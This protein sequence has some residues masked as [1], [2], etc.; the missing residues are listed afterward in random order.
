VTDE[1]P[2][3]SGS[4]WEPAAHPRPTPAASA[5]PAASGRPRPAGARRGVLAAAVAGLVAVGGLGGL[6]FGHASTDED[7]GQTGQVSQ[8]G[9]GDDRPAL[10]GSDDQG[11]GSGAAQPGSP[12]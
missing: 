10:P 8:L 2:L 6:A 7:S 9:T 4:R 1:N 5:A 11:S 12:T 3:H